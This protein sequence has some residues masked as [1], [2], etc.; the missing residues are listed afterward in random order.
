MK[1]KVF[2]TSVP[3]AGSQRGRCFAFICL[4]LGIRAEVQKQQKV[5]NKDFF[6][7]IQNI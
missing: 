1:E 2:P 3:F 6:R 5:F 4:L 7:E